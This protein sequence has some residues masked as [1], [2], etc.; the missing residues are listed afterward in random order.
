LVLEVS[1]SSK[2]ILIGGEISS[3]YWPD[4][5]FHKKAIKKIPAMEILAINRIIM[6]F[7][8]YYSGLKLQLITG[9]ALDTSHGRR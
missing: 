2:S 7:M 3:S 6:T 9:A 4:F 8:I 1:S 5:T